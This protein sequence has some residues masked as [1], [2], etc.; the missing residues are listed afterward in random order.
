[1]KNNDATNPNQYYVYTLT[2]PRKHKIFYVG[3]GKGKRPFA[4]ANEARR[5]CECQ[6]C[7]TIRSVWDAGK[8]VRIDYVYETDTS[9][10]ALLYEKQL[11]ADIGLYS[12]CNRNSGGTS[13]AIE[14]GYHQG[15]ADHIREVRYQIRQEEL[16][17]RKK[18]LEEGTITTREIPY[19]TKQI[20]EDL[21][22]PL[23]SKPPPW[24]ERII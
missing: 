12:L 17:R 21:A 13:A 18:Q 14:T 24:L 22:E 3:K 4:H 15:T 1:M 20:K 5:G 9:R 6:K 7:I 19:W 8:D 2:D 10:D 16:K 23:V 11:I